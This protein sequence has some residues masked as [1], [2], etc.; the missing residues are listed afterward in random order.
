[1]EVVVGAQLALQG[2]HVGDGARALVAK[3]DGP[4]LVAA[5][6]VAAV[7]E[8]P[9]LEGEDAPD[10][11][12]IDVRQQPAVGLAREEGDDLEVPA[13]GIAVEISLQPP[14]PHLRE[15]LVSLL[16]GEEDGDD[17]GRTAR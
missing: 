15:R 11:V 13:G 4:R 6:A 10:L 2:Q 7:A 3:P 16:A 9:G 12:L 5:A 14:E 1:M 8:S 17:E